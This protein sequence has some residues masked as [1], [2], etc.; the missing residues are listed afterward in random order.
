MKKKLTFITLTLVMFLFCLELA[1]RDA[2]AATT[3]TISY[4]ANGGSGAPATQY[5]SYNQT[6]SL[7][8][9]RP[10]RTGY[11]FLGWATTRTASYASYHPSSPFSEN[12]SVTLYALWQKNTY[13]IKF[14]ANGGSGAPSSRTK[15][16]G[17]PIT[18]NTTKPSRYGYTF[19]GWSRSSSATTASYYPGGYFNVDGNMT[20]Y[21]VWKANA[22]TVSYNANGGSGAPA[23]QTQYHDRTLNLSSTRP[24]RTGYTFK[25]WATTSNATSAIYYPS[26]PFRENR[27]VT[28][29]AVWQ[30][31]TYTINFNA[32]GGSGAPSSRTKTHGIPI[33]LDTTKPSRTGFS[34][35]GWSKS[36]SASTAS[37]YPGGYFN[38]DGNMTLYAV[39]KANEYTVSYNANGGSG[40][41]ASQIQYHDQT[42]NLSSTKPIRTG[43]TF[44]GWAT[45]STATSPTYYPSS[46]FRENR[47]VTLYAVWEKTKYTI[48][49]NAN[50]GTDAPAS[51]IKIHGTSLTLTSRKPTRTGYT[52]LGWSKSSTATSATYLPLATFTE[53]A[54]TTLY[55]VWKEI[56]Y[57]ISY[58][59]NDGTGIF[60]RQTKKY[61]STLSLT[62]TKPTRTNYKFKG[63]ATTSTATTPTYYPSSPFNENR[64]VTLYAVWERIKY[65]IS[66][67]ANGGT[68][69]PA[70][71][72]RYAGSDLRLSTT[73]PTKPGYRF[74]GW[75]NA[76]N[77]T[78]V[79][80]QPAGIYRENR[81]LRLYA[82]WEK[83]T[84][85]ISY[86]S[87][88]GSNAPSSQTKNHDVT[89]NL[90]SKEP[91]PPTGYK[92][93]GWCTNSS[94]S[95]VSYYPSA[96]FN[97]NRNVTLY[98]V[99]E[100]KQYPILYN[101]NG[102]TNAPASQKK[103]HGVDL[104]LTTE[105]PTRE[106]YKFIGW[107]RNNPSFGGQEYYQ[108]GEK[109]SL[110]AGFVL[111]ARWEKTDSL[112]IDYA[113]NGDLWYGSSGNA[114]TEFPLTP[115]D[116]KD[117][118][119]HSSGLGY[120]DPSYSF[121]TALGQTCY[122]L[123]ISSDSEFTLSSSDYSKIKFYDMST[124]SY[125]STLK[126]NATGNATKQIA[127]YISDSFTQNAYSLSEVKY[128]DYLKYKIYVKNSTN[129]KSLNLYQQEPKINGYSRS[130]FKEILNNNELLNLLDTNTL[131]YLLGCKGTTS[132]I[133]SKKYFDDGNTASYV[134]YDVSKSTNN[135]GLVVSWCT[136]D[137]TTSSKKFDLIMTNNM[138]MYITNNPNGYI[139]Q[140][141]SYAY[142]LDGKNM[143]I[144]AKSEDKLEGVIDMT[145]WAGNKLLS[146]AVS[147]VVDITI[148]DEMIGGVASETIENYLGEE[149]FGDLSQ[150]DK[151]NLITK[152]K[153]GQLCL[154]DENK[155]GR[156]IISQIGGQVQS[157]AIYPGI[158]HDISFTV[159]ISFSNKSTVFKHN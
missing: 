142:S 65:T 57:T 25:G 9:G 149:I 33:T 34:F 10:T 127:V 36:S 1:P 154:G 79:A 117:K 99:Y 42:L 90:S 129:T 120:L 157:T 48:S 4:N 69:A 23:S 18:L 40:A 28:L 85:T 41:P 97:E 111:Y 133:I 58:D 52:F 70:S 53:N 21:A 27:S 131:L 20:L 16:H 77:S 107:R 130:E 7:R 98:A 141:T 138:G 14:S 92:F 134:T 50:G 62:S 119:T 61:H 94:L 17:V 156:S 39:W 153:T 151:A 143:I 66:Y 44:K 47:S 11:T 155:N 82:L 101:A 113:S 26:S 89:L 124:K 78:L 56:T 5:K 31:N 86:N 112:D 152:G 13:T 60:A 49:Y 2:F 68:G 140:F 24:T 80:Y 35:L 51:Q 38:E 71:Q 115:E 93:V 116:E 158:Y 88:M 72:I 37:Y 55:A 109:F 81:S 12:R 145:T 30:K 103:T 114:T 45:A 73:V 137:I 64:N 126:V 63:W 147:S 128:V 104:T 46:P 76:I 150:A 106:G 74:K 110:N 59:A 83:A 15:T 102:G 139:T 121:N 54:N 22:Y 136:F 159:G 144:A 123:N 100:R 118:S 3:Y 29:Y 19:L 75:A 105:T 32:N 148:P 108:P 135:N 87:T 84:Y 125:G 6:I 67:D 132:N 43:Y 96:P 122:I 95:S 146:K 91:T 8:S